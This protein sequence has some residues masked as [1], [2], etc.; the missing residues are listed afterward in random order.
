MGSSGIQVGLYESNLDWLHQLEVQYDASTFDTDPFEPQPSG[1]N[2]IFPFWVPRSNGAPGSGDQSG[3]LDGYI[4]FPYTLPQDS[5][6][7]LLL[8]EAT[9]EIWVRKLNWIAKHGGMVLLDV[10][11]DYMS[12]DTSRQTSTQYPVTLYRQFLHYVKTRY[13]GQYW[14][15]LPKQVASSV[16]M[17]LKPHNTLDGLRSRRL[18]GKRAA[19]LLFSHYPAVPRPRRAAEALATHGVTVD[20][21]FFSMAAMTTHRNLMAPSM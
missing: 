5:T 15:V 17:A 9:P 12:F 18:F 8:R 1:G 2:T 6:L 13:A 19:V 16:R 4:E 20:L 14:H 11:P 7:F 10:H 21:I 3:S